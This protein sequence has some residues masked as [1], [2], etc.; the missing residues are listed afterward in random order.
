V[1]KVLVGLVVVAVAVVIAL[2]L[3]KG[4]GAGGAGTASLQDSAPP[5][6]A[7]FLDRDMTARAV[8]R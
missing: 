3:I 2:Q 1:G 7:R 4:E 6:D 8:R 5:A